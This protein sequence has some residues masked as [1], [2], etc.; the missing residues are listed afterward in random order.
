MQPSQGMDAPCI[1]STKVNVYTLERD[2]AKK[3]LADFFL[4]ASNTTIIMKKVIKKTKRK[5][6]LRK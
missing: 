2:T 1:Q 5:K 3:F 6:K 4:K